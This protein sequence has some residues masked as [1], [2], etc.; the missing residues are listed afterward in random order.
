[1]WFLID[2]MPEISVFL[3]IIFM[4][5]TITVMPW[6]APLFMQSGGAGLKFSPIFTYRP[7][8]SKPNLFKVIGA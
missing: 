6:L 4:A 2:D 8:Y 5:I 3:S 1:M 7:S